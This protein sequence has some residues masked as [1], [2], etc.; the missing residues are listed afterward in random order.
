MA[1]V[2]KDLFSPSPSAPDIDLLQVKAAGFRIGEPDIVMVHDSE[3]R[4]LN[5]G[6]PPL[7]EQLD[8]AIRNGAKVFNP[9][10]MGR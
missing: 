3:G 7:K 8:W 6:L 4:R 2:Y 1:S 10:Q 5:I 9:L